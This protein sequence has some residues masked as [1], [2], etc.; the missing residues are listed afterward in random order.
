MNKKKNQ[1]LSRYFG[2]G[3]IVAATG[4]GAGDLITASVA[5]AHFGTVIL[6]TAIVGGL[7]KYFLNEGIARWQLATETT[8]L[9]GWIKKLPKL[10]S[11]YFFIY[12]LLWSFIVAATEISF[13]GLSA[14]TVFPLPFLEQTSVLIWGILHSLV[15]FVLVYFSRYQLIENLMKFFIGLMFGV[16]IISAVLS[17]PDW[18]AILQ[19]LIN[20]GL[21]D[22]KQA[23]V[24]LFAVLGGVGGSVT[25]LSYAYWLREKGW[26]GSSFMSIARVDLAIAYGMMAL[27]G[28]A[29]IIIAAGVEAEKV[30]GYKMIMS[31]ADRLSEGTGWVGKWFF[32]L[33]FW[34][35]VFSS[36]IGV[37]NGIPYLFADFMQHFGQKEQTSEPQAISTNSFY[38][39]LFL[40]YLTFPPI[41]IVAYGRPVWIGIVYAV[42]GAFFMPF[43][44]SLLLYM[45]N[46]KE[47][48]KG[49]KNDWITNGVLLVTLFLFLGM[50][51]KKFV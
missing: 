33:G 19:S 49:F 34:G 8:L 50:L 18:G 20:P 31:I 47:W 14:H 44:A 38:Y 15:A 11:I 39:R 42:T 22:D 27:F 28:V 48:V 45:N 24:I 26:N 21:P 1:S 10:V 6:W 37:W 46:K 36:M 23:V 17:N 16:V 5:G 25:L 43:L 41:L 51:V 40:V 7:L 13:C 32:I 12:L 9:E 2:P 3:F 29:M 35:A 30:N 4:V